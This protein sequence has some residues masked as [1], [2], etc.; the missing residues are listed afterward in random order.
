V[1]TILPVEVLGLATAKTG[2]A[3]RAGDLGRSPTF[4]DANTTNTG[5]NGVLAY[6]RQS[7]GPKGKLG[8]PRAPYHLEIC[9][10]NRCPIDCFFCSYEQR[11]RAGLQLD[12]E[13]LSS[14]LDEAREMGTLGV[15]FSG[16]GDP[17][18]AAR[19]DALISKAAEFSGVAVQTN[20]V[21]L[22][23][24][25][26][27]GYRWFNT[28]CDLIS[29]SIY[30]PSEA[31]FKTVCQ[32]DAA[33]FT[34]MKNNMARAVQFRDQWAGEEGAGEDRL[35]PV[36]LS[37]KIVLSRENYRHLPELVAFAKS[38]ELDS[39]HIRLVDN[40]EPGQ[41][42]ALSAEQ[43]REL[44]TLATASAEPLLLQFGEFLTQRRPEP[45]PCPN[46]SLHFGLNAIIETTGE[47]FLSIPSDGPSHFS[48][49]NIK[50]EKLS[51]IWGGP[52]HKEVIDR[53]ETITFPVTK[54]RHHKIN[55][56]IHDHLTGRHRYE[57][58]SDMLTPR[59]FRYHLRAQI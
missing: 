38:F 25:L 18:V 50:K 19:V 20:A 31:L 35:P 3:T 13:L 53:L 30:A 57:F 9:P 2:S 22:D 32:A 46:Y 29:W 12:A 1:P 21:A 14:V 48:I 7:A 37:G 16:G 26:E 24:L 41:D 44:R 58:S 54:D 51:T 10:T 11:N 17:L 23:R 49:G 27:H 4:F 52:R 59:N 43:M 42:V 5:L 47:V 55:M 6:L 39:Y 15:Y 28:Q 34:R 8:I 45:A 36:H 56:A 33:K 40:F